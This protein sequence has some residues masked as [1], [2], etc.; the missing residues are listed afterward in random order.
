LLDLNENTFLSPFNLAKFDFA[1]P[2]GHSYRVAF[3][4]NNHIK[5]N[6]SKTVCA[7]LLRWHFF[8]SYNPSLPSPSSFGKE[9]DLNNDR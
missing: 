6:S 9:I 4:Y 2:D 8:V 1:L 3:V 7:C 5:S